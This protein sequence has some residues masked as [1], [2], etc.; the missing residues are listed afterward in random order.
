[1]SV[2][3]KPGQ[4]QFTRMPSAANAAARL[5]VMLITAALLTAYTRPVGEGTLPAIDARLTITPRLAACMVGSTACAHNSTALALTSSTSSQ[6]PSVM[7]SSAI[8][9]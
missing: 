9:R 3:M 8:V 2:S 7:P 5:R 1:M 4:T 6:W